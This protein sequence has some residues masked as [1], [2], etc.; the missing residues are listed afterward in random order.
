MSVTGFTLQK[1][2]SGLKITGPCTCGSCSAF[3]TRRTCAENESLIDYASC[4]GGLCTSQPLCLPVSKKDCYIG[5]SSKGEDPLLSVAKISANGI[6]C[7]YDLS[8]LDT[9]DQVTNY[10]DKFGKSDV[11]AENYCMKPNKNNLAR[12]SD[13]S[14]DKWCSV[15]LNQASPVIK[16][17][18]VNNYC[19]KYK[20]SSDCK[21]VNR[22][23]D[24]LYQKIK[25]S[26]NFSDACWYI[27]CA[28]DPTQLKSSD[29]EKPICPTS[30]CQSIV[31][32]MQARDVS[33][34]DVSGKINCDFT[35]YS[36]SEK[37]VIKSSEKPPIKPVIKSPL[38]INSKITLIKS[39]DF[40]P[41]LLIAIILTVLIFFLTL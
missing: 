16:T 30:Y 1:D 13:P 26:K 28:A 18:A 22:A 11:V 38:I 33:V 2:K 39:R 34:K 20:D 35:N 31:Q 23:I 41:F 24:P 10:F 17:V 29:L 14:T 12:A 8:K 36:K 27:P 40:K 9:T 3:T 7:K 4:C 32:V 5:K 25:S 15:W 37:P 21:C 6:K 19:K